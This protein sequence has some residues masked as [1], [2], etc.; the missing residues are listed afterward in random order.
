M[1][2]TIAWLDDVHELTVTS[3]C[4]HELSM[5]ESLV[6]TGSRKDY[7]VHFERFEG[8]HIAKFFVEEPL[9]L[10]EELFLIVNNKRFSVY[11]G[12]IVRTDWFEENY[13][14]ETEVLGAICTRNETTFTL[15]APTATFVTLY[16]KNKKLSLNKCEKGIWKRVVPGDWHGE[17]Y[18]YELVVNGE[19]VRAIDPYVKALQANSKTGVVVDLQRIE[20]ETLDQERSL[21]SIHDAIIYEIHVRDATICE[22]SGVKK[23]GAFSGLTETNTTT[24][25]GFSTGISYI[26]SLGVTHVQLLP[27][28]DFARVDECNPH[29]SYNWG[30]DPLFFQ[31]PEGSYASNVT[32]PLVRIQECK[33][34]I[35]A[36]HK[37]NLGVIVD[38]V[39]NHVYI[40]EESPFEKIVPGYYF[41]YDQHQ[42]ISNGTGVGND[43][44]SERTMAQKFILD[45][46]DYWLTEFQVDGFRFDL[47]GSIDLNTMKKI[48]Q[49]CVK[50]GRPIVLLGEGWDLP[51]ALPYSMKTTADKAEDIPNISFFNDFFRD[52]LKGELFNEGAQGYVNGGGK[53]IERLP[54]LI[55]GSVLEEYGTPFVSLPSQSINYVEC[56]DNHTLWDRLLK[57]NPSQS[58]ETRKK[59]HQLATGLTILSQGVPFIHAGQEWFRTKKG[60]G[61]S[62]ISG[63]E[64]NQLSWK[65]RELEDRNINFIRTLIEVR[66]KYPVFRLHSKEQIRNHIHILKSAAQFLVLPF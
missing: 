11:P 42:N 52:S 37:E 55:T 26:K 32:D 12:A 49:R 46:V 40:M 28:N 30:Y 19:A 6:V 53:Y 64:V 22:W 5:N 54:F 10:G 23:K 4:L 33:E 66:K 13:T 58:E 1:S 45:T 14:N 47:M 39:Y 63:D 27:I 25:S 29:S 24:P 21:P 38:V 60:D 15:W 59:I 7:S 20:L 61:N 41:R 56:H 2:S 65:S 35:L 36:F 3:D 8:E 16:L 44:A 48:E 9:P 62:Y 31:V 57:T 43:F 17:T 34:M 18:E 51:T 50:E